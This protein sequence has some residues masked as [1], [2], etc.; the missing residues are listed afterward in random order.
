MDFAASST[1][2]PVGERLHH[3]RPERPRTVGATYN[4]PIETLTA[5]EI[6]T[7]MA[8][9]T[10]QSKMRSV[11]GGKQT[12]AP[13]VAAEVSGSYLRLPRFKGTTDFPDTPIHPM[14]ERGTPMG[15]D[16]A[17]VGELDPKRN[18]INAYAAILKWMKTARTASC[19]IGGIVRMPC[20]KGKTVLVIKAMVDSGVRCVF[21]APSNVLL[22][23][24]VA[25][26]H[27]YAPNAKIAI[28]QQDKCDTAGADIIV[29]MQHSLAG[30]TYPPETF[31][32]VGFVVFDEVHKSCARKMSRAIVKQWARGPAM[33]MGVSATPKRNDGFDAILAWHFGPEIF[34]MDPDDTDTG[35]ANVEMCGFDEQEHRVR[36]YK[37]K[38]GDWNLAK[39]LTCI[40]DDVNRTLSIAKMMVIVV[41]HGRRPVVMAHRKHHVCM[42]GEFYNTMLKCY[43][44]AN[45]HKPA[46]A[47]DT[48]AYATRVL[49]IPSVEEALTEE[50]EQTALQLVVT[51]KQAF[52]SR[53]YALS[54]LAGTLESKKKSI[55]NLTNRTND[56]CCKVVCHRATEEEMALSGI[57]VATYQLFRDGVDVE[58]RD[59][60]FLASPVS[61]V[62][63]ACGRVQRLMRGKLPPLVIDCVD[64]H[65]SYKNQFKTR[66]RQYKKFRCFESGKTGPLP[67]DHAQ[68]E[69]WLWNLFCTADVLPDAAMCDANPLT[70]A[71]KDQSATS[72]PVSRFT[73]ASNKKVIDSNY[74]GMAAGHST[75][76]SS[77][78]LEK[79]VNRQHRMD[80]APITQFFNPVVVERSTTLTK[81]LPAQN[82][83]LY[84]QQN[85]KRQRTD[86][87]KAPM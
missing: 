19:G 63:Q 53:L 69:A 6:A 49:C 46:S 58:N 70:T 18:Q 11:G 4:I 7:L 2:T 68:C 40:A 38:V 45:G 51:V 20:G 73:F 37:G 26:L 8:S 10:V 56:P 17:F 60:L 12:E 64:P 77:S 13:L 85:R 32:G 35:Y 82:A 52:D 42:L 22:K 48:A 39:N 14:I 86:N 74:A 24:V 34:G 31:A 72:C 25:R 43:V 65:A 57:I 27:H 28:V 36:G 30:R 59:T 55:E 71:S 29:A 61:A 66:K 62:V 78:R 84:P 41:V 5:A 75:S 87:A 54:V 21:V 1:P 83:L 15:K 50:E 67:D 76:S 79:L 47:T 9:S 23:Q 44:D 80:D 81:A 16:V 33:I 3:P